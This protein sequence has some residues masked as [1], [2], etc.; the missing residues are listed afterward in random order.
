MT[1]PAT[2]GRGDGRDLV[3]GSDAVTVAGMA[4]APAVGT[5]K[6][7]V[8]RVA[9]CRPDASYA[10]LVRRFRDRRAEGERRPAQAAPWRDGPA[11]S[12]STAGELRLSNSYCAFF[13]SAFPEA[14]RSKSR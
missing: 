6:P 5:A 9:S 8:I 4:M 7:D 10:I 11:W 1:G 2:E 12:T 13:E 3:H 14:R